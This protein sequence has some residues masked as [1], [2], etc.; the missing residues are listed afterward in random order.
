MASAVANIL[1]KTAF[2]VQPAGGRRGAAPFPYHDLLKTK[3]QFDEPVATPGG[4]FRQNSLTMA[5][6]NFVRGG[7]GR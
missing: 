4:G 1:I 2:I 3:R 6:R 5:R 7:G